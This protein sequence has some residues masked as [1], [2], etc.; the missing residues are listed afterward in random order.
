LLVEVLTGIRE[1]LPFAVL[2]F[3]TDNDSPTDTFRPPT[4]ARAQAR[5]AGSERDLWQHGSN[6]ST[7]VFRL[8]RLHPA[9]R[10]RP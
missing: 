1:H 5:E 8:Q 6:A 10:K 4:P 3:D 9:A 2:G 7:P